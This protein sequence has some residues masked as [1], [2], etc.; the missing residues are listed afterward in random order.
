VSA[1][2]GTTGPTGRS[3]HAV[4]FDPTG[5]RRRTVN[6]LGTA[7]G[8]ALGVSSTLFL[9]S[10]LAVPFL[11]RTPMSG[12]A[13]G[14]SAGVSR[15]DARLSRH[16][17]RRSRLALFREMSVGRRGSAARPTG[18]PA[19]S[20]PIVAAFYVIWQPGGVQALRDNADRL[21]HVMPEWLHLNRNGTGLDFRD[22][23]PEVTLS[24]RDVIIA[25]R[26]HH[27]AIL[28]VFNNAEGGVF[29]PER[30]H[31]ALATEASRGA[32]AHAIRQFLVE[33]DFQGI[34]VDLENLRPEDYPKLPPFVAALRDSLQ[35]D[36]LAVSVDLEADHVTAL[37]RALSGAADFVVLMSY[38][39][40]APSGAPGPLAG[41]GWFDTLLTRAAAVVPAE[42][43]VVGVGNYAIDWP[44]RRGSGS[45][46]AL[47]VQASLAE[48]RDARPNDP[49]DSLVDF[50]PTQLNPTFDYTDASGAPHEV[51][52]L[53]GVTAYNELVLAGRSR[54]RGAALWAL[55]AEDPS[56]WRTFGKAELGHLPAPQ[57]LDSV[58]TS[59]IPAYIGEGEILSVGAL[60]RPGLRRTELD[61]QLDLLTDETYR[62]LPSPFVIRRSGYR[63]GLLALT[64]DDGPDDLYTPE[65]LDELDRLDVK[66]TFFLV[67]QNVERY[68]E[69]VRRI[70]ED[71]HEIGNHTFTHPNMAVVSA[72]RGALELNATLRA[73]QATTGH[74]TTLFRVP[75]NMDA[76]P[77]NVEEA[78][79]L[80]LASSLGYVTVGEQLDPQDWNL[81]KTG[82]AGQRMERGTVDLVTTL[83]SQA[84][85]VHGNVILL[86]SAGG[87]RSRTVRALA[88]VVPLLQREG[89]RFVTVSDLMGT[90]REAVM[91]AIERRDL[92]VVG[93]DRVGFDALYVLETLLAVGFSVAIA[94]AVLRLALIVPLAVVADRRSRRRSFDPAFRP[95]VSVLIAA[96]NE[97]PVIAR[98]VR[99]V[100]GSDY[101]DLEVIVV[102]DGSTDGTA[103]A[104]EAAFGPDPRVRLL[105]QA[106]T[107]KAGALNH[108]LGVARGEVLVA[109]DADTMVAPDAVRLLAR[110][111]ADPQVGAVAGNVKVGNRVNGL[112]IWQSIEYISAQNLDRRANAMLNGVTVVPGA[113]GAWRR[114]AVLDAGGFL[115]DTLAEDMELTWRLRRAGW[116]IDADVEPVGLTEAP[117][118]LGQFLRQ[119]Q[120]WAFGSLQVLWKHRA[121]LFRLG[122]FGW[123]AVPSVWLFQIVF[124]TLGPLV[125]LQVAY[126]VLDF[127]YSAVVRVAFH[128]DW[129]PL[130]Q[131]TQTLLQT[132][133]FYAVFFAVD[134]AAAFIAFRL[135]RERTK[136]LWWLFLQRFVYR[137]TL[138]YVLWKSVVSALKGRRRAW[139]K[140]RRMGTVT[141]GA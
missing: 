127:L 126:A 98:T 40:H 92:L 83:L 25:A 63:P 114:S 53:D 136:D 23:D 72:R 86:H 9:I 19:P 80:I 35:D 54:V 36:R 84:R 15:R 26:Q 108:A 117:A 106:N 125:D 115:T 57:V 61:A 88:E 12:A 55:G 79:A 141:A 118:T 73:I 34:N 52:G 104:V 1:P 6:R 41:I 65:I 109:F 140:L 138:Y 27:L 5:R 89:F 28:P 39:E 56:V 77:G 68:P 103:A 93:L 87:D 2:E 48:A 60:P 44:L 124:Q 67:G 82:G 119:R 81:W 121:V 128:Q 49:P 132:L 7:L 70:Y 122:W 110:H 51:W 100:L 139:G 74:S 94:L 105:P 102:D 14:R 20:E 120:R 135:D 46:R 18:V 116:R 13:A 22:W 58:P 71:G 37:G 8:L 91:P 101:P 32:I 112:T 66:G 11:P 131:V 33:H 42:K 123:V 96:Y 24:N 130:P 31:V 43:L 99:S 134:L 64:F 75:Y 113:I 107:G 16:I 50:D 90:T 76:E 111:F 10:L 3:H 29:D 129:Q 69:V 17:A 62:E 30:A 78:R 95:P 137:Q 47:T 4:F 45:G 97:E 38:A 21:T 133:F 85:T 59:Y